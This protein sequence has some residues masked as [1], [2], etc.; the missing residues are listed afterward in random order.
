MMLDVVEVVVVVME[1]IFGEILIVD[2]DSQDGLFEMMCDVV[3]W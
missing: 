1:G 2:N 3:V